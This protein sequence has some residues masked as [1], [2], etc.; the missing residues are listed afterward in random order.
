MN[1]FTKNNISLLVPPNS[2]GVIVYLPF[3]NYAEVVDSEDI[4][5]LESS[6]KNEAKDYPKL[7]NILKKIIKNKS[8][9]YKTPRT[10]DGM[11]SLMLLPNN[12]CNFHC[13]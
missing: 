7:N 6:L 2:Q 9:L 4:I 13:S 11:R 3:A 5:N 12:K 1:I 10:I 8:H